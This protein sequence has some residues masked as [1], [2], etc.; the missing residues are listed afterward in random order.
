MFKRLRDW[1]RF[2]PLMNWLRRYFGVVEEPVPCL[3]D[4]TRGKSKRER[5]RGRSRSVPPSER[6]IFAM[7]LLMIALVGLIVLE[8][9]YIVV[10]GTVNSEMIA[11]ITGLIGGIVTAFLMGKK[12]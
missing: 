10:T 4:T 12:S 1:V 5:R 6:F 2:K 8:A 3:R 11:A 7:V 9:I